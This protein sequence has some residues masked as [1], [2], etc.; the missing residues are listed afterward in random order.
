MKRLLLPSKKRKK[1]GYQIAIE[2]RIEQ[3]KEYVG[4]EEQTE[5]K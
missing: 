1:K 5:K 3:S 4:N 2:C